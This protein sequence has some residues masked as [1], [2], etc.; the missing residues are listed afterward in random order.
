LFHDIASIAGITQSGRLSD[1]L[2]RVIHS[3]EIHYE[4]GKSNGHHSKFSIL[5]RR[6]TEHTEDSIDAF[7][8]G[9]QERMDANVSSVGNHACHGHGVV[10]VVQRSEEG[11]RFT[12]GLVM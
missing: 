10:D 5:Q 3:D 6:T 4:R 12:T 2:P 1:R 9:R 7:V 8:N 11:H